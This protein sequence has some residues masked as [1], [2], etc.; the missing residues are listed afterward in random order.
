[1]DVDNI[2]SGPG[3]FVWGLNADGTEKVGA[4]TIDLTQGG[5][6]FFSETTY[7]E[8]TTDQTGTA[9]VKSIKTG[10]ISRVEMQ[11]PDMDFLKV[12]SFNPDVNKVVDGV[13]ANKIKYQ[14]AGLAG[15]ELPTELAVIKPQGITDPNRFIYIQKCAI[16]FDVDANFLLDGNQTMGIAGVGY[17]D[18]DAVPRG[19]IYSWGDISATA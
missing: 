7:F 14:V 11:T 10:T 9:P 12:L 16:K 6:R 1:M 2:Y 3:I 15:S 18:L 19:L 17:P 8:P 13:D 5:I 4:I